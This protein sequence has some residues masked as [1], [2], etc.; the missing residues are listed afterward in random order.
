[1]SDGSSNFSEGTRFDDDLRR[2]ERELE[3]IASE[4]AVLAARRSRVQVKVDL[5]RRLIEVER[6]DPTAP[7]LALP[8]TDLFE[9]K[10]PAKT[11]FAHSKPPKPQDKVTWVQAVTAWVAS[12]PTGLTHA[13][14]KNQML[15]SDFGPKFRV[16]E[17]GYYNALS[18]LQNRQKIKKHGNRLYTAEALEDYLRGVEQGR[19]LERPEALVGAHSP[20]GEAVLD[21]VHRNRFQGIKSPDIVAELKNDVEFRASLT[22]HQT[23]AFNIIARLVRRK[24]IIR[25]ADGQ[26]FPGP[27]I[28]DRNKDSKWLKPPTPAEGDPR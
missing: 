16:S 1:M 7:V 24:Q 11:R 28:G 2:C 17:K 8:H 21:I 15:Q 10:T 5:L 14:L 9:H 13:E 20:M 12:A 18:R 4:E 22:P 19:I 26:C 6:A 27:L 23:G 3:E 25:N